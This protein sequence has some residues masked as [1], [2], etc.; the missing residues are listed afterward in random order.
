L[1]TGTAERSRGRGM[2]E[3]SSVRAGTS[4]ELICKHLD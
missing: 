3:T 2:M 4:V 1:M